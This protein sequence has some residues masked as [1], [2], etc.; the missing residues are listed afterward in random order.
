MR[1]ARRTLSLVLLSC[2]VAPRTAA[3]QVNIFQTG[4]V[5][6]VSAMSEANAFGSDMIGMLVTWRLAD[7]SQFQATWQDLGGGNCGVNSGGFQL[8]IGCTNATA[9]NNPF[10]LRNLTGG[11]LST[12]T[13][14]GAAARTVFDCGWVAPNCVQ[15]GSADGYEGTPGSLG[16]FTFTRNGGSYALGAVGLYTNLVG[17]GGAA[18]VGDLF[19]EFRMTFFGG[20]VN[21]DDF[22]FNIDT[23][24]TAP[25]VPP[26]TVVPEPRTFVLV[27]AGLSFLAAR[28]RRRRRMQ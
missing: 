15:N 27:G 19:E 8:M 9:G 22:L 17:L 16:G 20:F 5:H 14:N 12:V 28:A 23:D 24:E 3:A 11:T 26:P 1:H 7:A 10:T 13:L 2:A 21:G 6:N 18:P 4:T 25:D